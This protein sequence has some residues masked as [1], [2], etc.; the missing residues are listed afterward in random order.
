MRLPS[1][2]E[3]VAAL[4]GLFA[5]SHSGPGRAGNRQ[6]FI[7]KAFDMKR[8]AERSGDHSF[9]AVVV[10]GSEIVGLGPSRVVAKKD[11]SA[12]A[13]REALQDAQ[14]KLGKSDLS[15]CVMY[16][17]SRPCGDCERAAAQTKLSRMYYGR[18]G[19][20]AGPPHGS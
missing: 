6:S 5:V 20:D 18:H 13:E 1:R 11:W 9:G 4:M 12:H 19:T 15:D 7:D 16:S 10:R 17:T 3:F 2:R 14:A 8:L